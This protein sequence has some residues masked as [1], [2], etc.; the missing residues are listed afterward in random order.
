MAASFS[1]KRVSGVAQKQAAPARSRTVRVCC[2][3]QGESHVQKAS[4]FA[5]FAAAALLQASP[6]S[7]GVILEQPQL[8][9]VLQGDDTPA[10]VVKREIIL[11]G[12]RS[13]QAKEGG[14]K[15]AA[16]PK[17]APEVSVQGGELDPKAVAL[18]GTLVLIGAGAFALTKLDEGF[19]EY[20][21]DASCKN[22]G[23]IG[24]GYE[25]AIKGGALAAGGGK[26]KSRPASKPGTKKVKAA[27][28][29]GTG[30]S[31]GGLL[32]KE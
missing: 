21:D 3:K 18:P 27:G 11:P 19:L 23:E 2:S 14:A 4:A 15:A 25:T 31:L 30:F 22:S 5:A 17:R 9:K 26:P 7:A 12:Q 8:K 10:A 6:A 16:A 28:K 24:A 32:N 29:P 1:T 13:K 20:M